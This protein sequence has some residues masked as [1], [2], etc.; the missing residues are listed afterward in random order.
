MSE[1]HLADKGED[2]EQKI[3]FED[4]NFDSSTIFGDNDNPESFSFVDF[5]L[6]RDYFQMLSCYS[7]CNADIKV[8]HNLWSTG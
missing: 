2:H 1:V 5:L 3:V 7:D 4:L 8:T 6:S